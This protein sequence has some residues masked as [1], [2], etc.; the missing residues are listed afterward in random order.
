M[1]G[2]T[3]F[4]VL[5][6]ML[7]VAMLLTGCGGD[8][9]AAGSADSPSIIQ[10]YGEA[11]ITAEPDQAKI[12][13]AIMTRDTSAEDAVKEN[14]RLANAVL[15]ALK[16]YGLTDEELKTSSYT[17]YTYRDRVREQPAME[18]ETTYYQATNEIIATTDKLDAVGEIV[19]LT[20]KAG[21]NNINY[22]SFELKDPQELLMEALGAATEQ[23]FRKAEAIAE[24]AGQKLGGLH[25]IKEE[26]SDYVPFRLRDE[27]VQEEM[28]MGSAETPITPGDIIVRG[29]VTAEYT[30]K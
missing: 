11:E 23:A 3:I 13:I 25:S 14:A 8:Q 21:A 6:A 18:E 22:I 17:L 28:A 15:D 30:L 29:T 1:H 9:P 4:I 5:A 19:D 26:R 7:V 2:K 24:S 12:S 20:V 10:T 27:M 16:D